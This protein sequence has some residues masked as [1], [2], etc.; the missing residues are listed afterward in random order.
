MMMMMTMLVGCYSAQSDVHVVRE[1]SP[2]LRLG[3]WLFAR[4]IVGEV[5][6]WHT[7]TTTTTTTSYVPMGSIH[8]T[9]VAVDSAAVHRIGEQRL[10]GMD[11]RR[12]MSVSVIAAVVVVVVVVIVAGMTPRRDDVK[13]RESHSSTAIATATG[14][15]RKTRRC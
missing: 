2:P 13:P 6:A 14:P 11:R 1:E 9:A 15:H 3:R 5:G 7:A 8:T 10:D 4:D 12:P